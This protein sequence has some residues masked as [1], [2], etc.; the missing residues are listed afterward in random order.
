MQLGKVCPVCGTHEW[1]YDQYIGLGL[2]FCGDCYQ[3][4]KDNGKLKIFL[5]AFKALNNK[6]EAPH[7]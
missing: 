4:V 3:E 6:K 2:S 5:D 1:N 7:V